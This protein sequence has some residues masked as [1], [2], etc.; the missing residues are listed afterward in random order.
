VPLGN[1]C[2]SIFFESNFANPQYEENLVP[3]LIISAY[4][5]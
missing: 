1:K 5:F 2:K 3:R 4:N